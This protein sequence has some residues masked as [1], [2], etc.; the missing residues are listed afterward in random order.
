V[1]K[2][3]NFV[4]LKLPFFY[5]VGLGGEL[6]TVADSEAE[7]SAH[8]LIKLPGSGAYSAQTEAHWAGVIFLR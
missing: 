8:P 1:Q 5:L 3:F 4:S 6:R 7:G 2:R